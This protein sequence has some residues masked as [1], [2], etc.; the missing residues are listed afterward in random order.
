MGYL[1]NRKITSQ[2]FCGICGVS[3]VEC[4]AGEV[5]GI[6]ARV[7]NGVD[8]ASLEIEKSDGASL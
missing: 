7:L 8:I 4:R 6:N 2:E 5:G 1:F 3:V